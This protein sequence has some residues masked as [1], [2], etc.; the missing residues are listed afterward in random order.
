MKKNLKLF[1]GMLLIAGFVTFVTADANARFWGWGRSAGY[2]K[3][4]LDGTVCETWSYYV[5]GISVSSEERCGP[6][7]N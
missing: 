2:S 6:C 7:C 4:Y 1:L 3:A 5:F